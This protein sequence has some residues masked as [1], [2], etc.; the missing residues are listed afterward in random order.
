[1]SGYVPS[2]E[3]LVTKIVVRD[4]K[5]LDVPSFH[6]MPELSGRETSKSNGD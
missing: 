1:M 4:M 3:Q 5:L 6:Q 2:T